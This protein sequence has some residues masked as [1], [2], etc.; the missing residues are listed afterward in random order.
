MERKSQSRKTTSAALLQIEGK[1]VSVDISGRSFRGINLFFLKKCHVEKFK[2][3]SII[4][5][6]IVTEG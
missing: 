5:I 1:S 2:I 6:I 3:K 4:I